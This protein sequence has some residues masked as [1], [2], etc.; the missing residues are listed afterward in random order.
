LF[1]HKA[2]T[3]HGSEVIRARSLTRLQN[4]EFREDALQSPDPSGYNVLHRDVIPTTRAFTSGA[5][6]LA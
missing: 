2:G 1:H 4:A 5:R 3:S 6:D